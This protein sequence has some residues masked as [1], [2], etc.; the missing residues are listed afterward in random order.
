MGIQCSDE[1]TMG[2]VHYSVN[3]NASVTVEIKV[4]HDASCQYSWRHEARP[5][6]WPSMIQTKSVAENNTYKQDSTHNLLRPPP[7]RAPQVNLPSTTTT[8]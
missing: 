1:N 3:S 8:A 4:K 5:Q 6:I 2:V 7:R